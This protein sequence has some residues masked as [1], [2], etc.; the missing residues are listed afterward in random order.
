MKFV[1]SSLIIHGLKMVVHVQMEVMMIVGMIT[2]KRTKFQNK[3]S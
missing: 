2:M 3:E 1:E